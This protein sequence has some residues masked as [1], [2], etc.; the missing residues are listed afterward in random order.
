MAEQVKKVKNVKKQFFEMNVPLSAS[1]VHLYGASAEEMNGKIVS[2]DLTR[3]LRGKNL[4]LKVR[5][6][7]GEEGLSGEL[8]SLQLAGVYIRRM[9][10]K[11]IDYVEDSFI[12]ESKDSTLIV[13]PFLITRNKVSRAVRRE[14]RNVC[15]E[16]LID[17]F[18]N[19]EAK[20]LFS[21]IMTGKLQKVLATRLKKVYPL[22]LCEIRWIEI[23][24]EE[25]VSARRMREAELE[26]AK[27]AR[28]S[29]EHDKIDEIKEINVKKEKKVK[30]KKSGEE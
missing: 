19:R 7:S 23:L 9:I 12:I 18:R 24:P 29:A 25:K 15:K 28:E 26:R 16:F 8:L 6:N 1:R 2:L 30:N 21:E 11:G 5:V 17:Y 22:G 14:L 20:E 10:R 27:T 3:S 13:K 4:I